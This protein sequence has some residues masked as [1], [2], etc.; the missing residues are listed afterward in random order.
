MN[1]KIIT[2][3]VIDRLE[4]VATSQDN[5]EFMRE[6]DWDSVSEY[7]LADMDASNNNGAYYFNCDIEEVTS[8][9]HKELVEYIA[10]NYNYKPPMQP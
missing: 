2:P 10:E 9:M 7:I 8:E 1:A 6:G 5:L 3:T 4:A